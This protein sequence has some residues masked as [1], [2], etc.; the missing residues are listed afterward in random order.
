MARRSYV[1]D[2][3]QLGGFTV[4]VRNDEVDKADA[5]MD[6]VKGLTVGV[7]MV[8]A[9]SLLAFGGEDALNEKLN[10]TGHRSG[11]TLEEEWEIFDRRARGEVRDMG[12]LGDDSHHVRVDLSGE[13]TEKSG[14][15][16]MIE[17]ALEHDPNVDAEELRTQLEESISQ[18]K[19]S[20][21]FMKGKAAVRQQLR[22]QVYG[23]L[24]ALPSERQA[25][26]LELMRA[27]GREKPGQPDV[28]QIFRCDFDK[29]LEGIEL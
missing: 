9:V 25:N 29:I 23:Q 3:F 13:G 2:A 15:D 4:E 22:E 27:N 1:P 7:P 8:E 14:I 16:R 26:V 20:I 10:P 24:E 28:V 21:A 11:L 12:P 17:Q 5:I 19:G 18:A 6:P